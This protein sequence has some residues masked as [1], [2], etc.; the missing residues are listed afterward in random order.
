M[1]F[2]ANASA[3]DWRLPIDIILFYIDSGLTT[4]QRIAAAGLV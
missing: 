1:S 2:F 3:P 4:N